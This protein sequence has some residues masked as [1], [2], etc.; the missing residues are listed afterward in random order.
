M[1]HTARTCKACA[2]L[3]HPLY[4]AQG[5]AL[6]KHLAANPFP[7]QDPNAARGEGK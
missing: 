7:T 4:A 1:K 3:R 6:T 5:R 2:L